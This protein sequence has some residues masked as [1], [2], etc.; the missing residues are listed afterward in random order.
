MATRGQ[1][2]EEGKGECKKEKESERCGNGNRE[3]ARGG[4][5]KKYMDRPPVY[6]RRENDLT[7]TTRGRRQ[8]YPGNKIRKYLAHRAYR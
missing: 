1:R 5:K 6:Y 8:R 2:K 4:G 7:R 3:E